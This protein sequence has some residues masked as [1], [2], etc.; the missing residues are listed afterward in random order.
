LEL[1]QDINIIKNI[2]FVFFTFFISESLF[3]QDSLKQGL[4][5]ESA[6]VKSKHIL[7]LSEQESF[8]ELSEH[9]LIWEDTSTQIPFKDILKIPAS[10]W[11]RS[12][13][14]HPNLGFS[15]SA[16]WIRFHL[17]DTTALKI[18]IFEL[19]YALLDEVD[20]YYKNVKGK[21]NVEK[22]GDARPF[23]DRS[24]KSRN[25]LYLLDFQEEINTFYV[26]VKSEGTLE[27][28]LHLRNPRTY[29]QDFISGEIMYGIFLGIFIF[30]ILN[31]LFLFFTLREYSYLLYV[32]YMLF[33]VIVLLFMSGHIYQYV[34][35]D[36]ADWGNTTY[37][38]FYAISVILVSAYG[39][40]FLKLP[41]Y[42]QTFCRLFLLGIFVN[43]S[44]L[45]SAF[46]FKYF[47]IIQLLNLS[48]LIAM[49]LS[50]SAGIWVY[51]KGN[52]AARFYLIAYALYF[53]SLVAL[54]MKD[55]GVG[56]I[57]AS[58]FASYGLEIG[59]FCEAVF[60]S[61]ALSDRYQIER[62]KAIKEKEEA[63]S[64]KIKMK[65]EANKNL[66]KKVRERTRE[67]MRNNEYL[68]EAERVS[69]EKSDALVDINAELMEAF[70]K[71]G[72][73]QKQ[74][75]QAE[76][77]A[78]LG[79]L[80][81]GIAHEINNPINY[82]SNSS[83]GLQ[84]VLQDLLSITKEY[85]KI[86]PDNI[87]EILSKI[88]RLKE[89]L[90]YDYL[91]ELSLELCVNIKNGVTH[92]AEIVKALRSF[93]YS[94][95]SYVPLDVHQVIENSLTMLRAEYKSDISIEKDYAEIPEII[96]D[97][98]QLSQVFLNLLNNA[99][100]A[101]HNKH[102]A[103]QKG[104]ITIKT[105]LKYNKVVLSIQDNG[106]GIPEDIK[107]RIFE[108]FFTSKDVGEGTGLGLYISFEIIQNHKGKI[109][110]KSQEGQSTTFFV[111]LPTKRD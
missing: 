12:E 19:D 69:R 95:E 107:N 71:L 80:V 82:I 20:I 9:I 43:F 22:V 4:G 63:Q 39:I 40:S 54:I 6:F 84:D 64:A 24:I 70:D 78:S 105:E 100:Q 18:W 81:A 86:T 48:T 16:Y 32:V 51:I 97:M 60:L 7:L 87:L 1:K 110:F 27:L 111:S 49:F 62:N 5:A 72:N 66:E 38:S 8:Y 17:R 94:K 31:N 21:W 88:E 67:I 44:L 47:Y 56:I 41:K 15:T 42:S 14:I 55:M 103:T 93:S 90:D 83:D 106:G 92:T 58:I 109:T 91:L 52:K 101:I 99:I 28:P 102:T 96:G 53:I 34:L 75:I 98:S 65:E 89:E 25:I 76:K 3:A 108:P 104:K 45:I 23:K 61:I 57:P 79:V 29:Y 37:L 13:T 35:K 73:A 74:L 59:L 85:E 36:V 33:S 26:R 10:Q 46:I 30:I 50:V 68:Q 2:F 11:E 77:M